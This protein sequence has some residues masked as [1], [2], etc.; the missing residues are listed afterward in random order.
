MS[1]KTLYKILLLLVAFVW[2]AGFPVIKI[3][4]NSGLSP[5]AIVAI[6]FLSVFLV[7][8]LYLWL[9]KINIT[10]HEMLI[11]SVSGLALGLGFTLQTVGLVHTTSSKN[12]FLT[13]A[14]VIWVPFFTWL[15]TKKNP[16]LNIYLSSIFCFGGIGLISLNEFKF[17]L[18]YGDFLTLMCA[19]FFSLQIVLLGTK[20]KNGKPVVINTFQMLSAGLFALILNIIF[21]DFSIIKVNFTRIQI[22]SLIYLILFNTLVAFLIQT[23]A[24]KILYPQIVTLILS[25]EMVFAALMSY[26]I[27]NDPITPRIFCGGLLIFISVIVSEIDFKKK[28]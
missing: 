21:E 4:L 11:G 22:I 1:K 8:Y 16:Q 2:G 19:I 26:I 12:A 17:Y 23:S 10:K 18:N 15:I 5:N 25:T 28:E 13:G 20:I 27:L 7:L 3:I 6:R 9:M 24:Q 14:Y